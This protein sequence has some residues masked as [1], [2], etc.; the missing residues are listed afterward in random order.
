MVFAT[1]KMLSLTRL[2]A[3]FSGLCQETVKVGTATILAAYRAIGVKMRPD[4]WRWNNPTK[5]AVD[6]PA[7][8]A[9]G[10]AG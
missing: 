7:K 1:V 4:A 6:Q 10:I 9:K 2:A 5:D 3:R 8:P